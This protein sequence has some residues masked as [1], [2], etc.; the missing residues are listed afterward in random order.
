MLLADWLFCFVFSF[1]DISPRMAITQV[2]ILNALPWIKECKN[3]KRGF[4]RSWEKA[5]SHLG[6]PI[7]PSIH[8]IYSHC[9]PIS[10]SPIKEQTIATYK[11]IRLAKA[12]QRGAIFVEAEWTSSG[13]ITIIID[14]VAAA[15]QWKSADH[16]FRVPKIPFSQ[17][18]YN[19]FYTLILS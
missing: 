18:F 8:L 17:N 19:F 16:I 6:F 14:S 7:A 1:I 15:F 9:L 10:F 11:E 4:S 2:I 5:S 13:C 3:Q 12:W